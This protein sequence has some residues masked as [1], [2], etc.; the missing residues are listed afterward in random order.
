MDDELRLS[1][2]DGDAGG[3]DMDGIQDASGLEVVFS[4]L[5]STGGWVRYKSE[6]AFDDC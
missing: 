4:P 3:L 1:A 5:I 2:V 6:V